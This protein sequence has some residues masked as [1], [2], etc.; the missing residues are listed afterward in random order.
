MQSCAARCWLT[1]GDG[2]CRIDCR[3]GR[4]DESLV[5]YM[6]PDPNRRVPGIAQSDRPP[7]RESC[8]CCK[9]EKGA[10]VA[11]CPDWSWRR[12]IDVR[13]RTTTPGKDGFLADRR[14]GS[15]GRPANVPPQLGLAPW[16]QSQAVAD[17]CP[18]PCKCA[19][20]ALGGQVRRGP[21]KD[22]RA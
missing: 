16:V 17:V 9:R 21:P 5:A 19:L 8:P 14:P 10:E 4:T 13:G 11:K 7:S 20:Y 6:P 12:K 15:L 1:V 18:P 3:R 22:N 2:G